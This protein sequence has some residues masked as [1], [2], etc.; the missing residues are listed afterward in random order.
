MRRPRSRLGIFGAIVLGALVL[1]ALAQAV[2]YG[3]AH[4]DPKATRPVSFA[5]AHERQLFARACGDCHSDRTRWPWYS[6]V[7][8]MSWLVQHDVEDGRQ[9]L[10]LSEWDRPQPGLD[11][12]TGVIGEG[13]M[14]P[15]QYT[16]IH[17]DAKLSSADR[18]DLAAAFAHLYTRTPPGG[19]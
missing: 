16:L 10:N 13:E 18:R 4:A 1:L 8:P 7:A 2:P 3:R 17:G 15:W 12:V 14:P 6:N 5:T 19:G 11:E 9:I